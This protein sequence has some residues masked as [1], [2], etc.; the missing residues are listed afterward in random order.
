[1]VSKRA[2]VS[3]GATLAPSAISHTTLAL[4]ARRRGTPSVCERTACT[5][6]TLVSSMRRSPLS[7]RARHR[8]RRATSSARGHDDEHHDER[9]RRQQP[10]CGRTAADSE[11]HVASPAPS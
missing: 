5:S 1:L 10:A 11:T 4:L 2:S 6:P 8:R 7:T 9:C 3:P